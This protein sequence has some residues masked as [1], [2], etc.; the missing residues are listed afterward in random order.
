MSVQT[1]VDKTSPLWKAWEAYKAG[2]EYENTKRWAT[3]PEH[4]EGSLW[5]A[6]CEGF[7]RACRYV[8]SGDSGT[9]RSGRQ[10]GSE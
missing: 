4:T 6:F 7:D 5:A 9:T 3:V 10:D 1:P 2:D 8:E